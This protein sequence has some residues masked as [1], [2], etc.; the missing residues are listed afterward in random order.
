MIFDPDGSG[1]YADAFT[2]LT[3][4][5]YEWQHTMG[6]IVNALISVGLKIEFLHEFPYSVF[7]QLPPMEQ[8]EDGWW[9]LKEGANPRFPT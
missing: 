4:P 1:T 3:T 6:D 8:H 7:Q 2:P 9:R 5:T